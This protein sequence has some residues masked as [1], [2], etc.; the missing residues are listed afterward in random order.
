[1]LVEL[2]QTNLTVIKEETVENLVPGGY[3][4][5][6]YMNL[7]M[8]VPTLHFNCYSLQYIEYFYL[9]S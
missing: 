9:F 3:L 1:M 7:E 6:E 8:E 2:A 5:S 4:D